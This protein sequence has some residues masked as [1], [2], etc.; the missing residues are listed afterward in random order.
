MVCEKLPC[1]LEMSD[2]RTEKLMCSRSET[3]DSL[4]TATRQLKEA[5]AACKS[6]EEAP[7]IAFISKMTLVVDY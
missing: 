4:P 7:V 2:A 5:F 1:P 3:F 6:T